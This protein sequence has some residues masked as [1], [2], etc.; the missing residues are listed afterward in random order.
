MKGIIVNM[1][2]KIEK[3]LAEFKK[4]KTIYQFQIREI[5]NID[6]KE[7]Y[8][9]EP[10]IDE[11]GKEIGDCEKWINVGYKRTGAYAKALSNLFRYEFEF[12]GQ[13]LSSIES[14]FQGIKFK[15]VE[16]QNLVFSYHSL[17]SNYVKVCSDYDWKKTGIL[18]WQGKEIDRYSSEYDDLVDEL[19]ISAIQNPLYRS[20]LK[21]CNREIIHTMGAKEKS[22]TVFTRYEFEKQLNCLKDFLKKGENG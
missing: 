8:N 21:N 14:F 6:G 18:Y 17:N 11:E 16:M 22:E 19:Y 3:E 5:E 2:K 20:L 15:N 7:Y 4:F 13:K 10:L 9:G 1:D 12:K